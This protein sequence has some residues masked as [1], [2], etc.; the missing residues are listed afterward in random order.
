MSVP[1]RLTALLSGWQATKGTVTAQSDGSSGDTDDRPL[2]V[3]AVTSHRPE[4]V[5]YSLVADSTDAEVLTVDSSAG[6]LARA[7]STYTQAKAAIQAHDPD[8]IL[9]DCYEIPGAVVTRLA[10]R[11]D[12][13]V[14]ARLV[15]N[16]WRGFEST[17]LRTVRSPADVARFLAHR[18]SYRLNNYVFDRADAYVAVSRE[19][20]EIIHERTGCPRERVGVVPVPVTENTLDTDAPQRLRRELGIDQRRIALTVTNLSFE[21][22]YEGVTTAVR[23]LEQLLAAN[24]DLAYVVAG[25]GRYYEAFQAAVAEMVDDRSVRCRIYTPGFVENI[26][27]LY[28]LA[29]VFVYVSY[30]DGYPNAVLEAQTAGL[31]VVANAAHGMRDQITHAETGYFVDPEQRGALREQVAELLADPDLARAIGQRARRR[32]EAENSPATVSQR[33]TDFLGQFRQ[34][35]GTERSAE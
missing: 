26:I 33:L 8:L 15:G 12:V 11:Y 34:E 17:T 6:R 35:Y 7:R 3:F 4:E 16:T 9:L 5:T 18:G 20:Q 21:A 25:D 24:P 22:K 32:V 2:S 29:D 14:V 13:P 28:A 10:Q 27:D 19:L 1:E 30:R 31:P 23:E